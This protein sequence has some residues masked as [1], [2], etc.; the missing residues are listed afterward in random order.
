MDEVADY[1]A[2]REIRRVLV[3]NRD[4]RLTGVISIGDLAKRSDQKK[5]GETIGTIA[6]APPSK[7]A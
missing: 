2:Q 1:M 3:M 4:K 7:A 6:Q 5:A